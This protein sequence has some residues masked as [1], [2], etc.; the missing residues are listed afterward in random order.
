MATIFKTMCFRYCFLNNVLRGAKLMVGGCLRGLWQRE[1][2]M[3][4]WKREGV[5]GRRPS[6]GGVGTRRVQGVSH[7]IYFIKLENGWYGVKYHVNFV[8]LGLRSTYDP[9]CTRV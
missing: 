8:F 3:W 6:W 1:G 4:F 9:C 5:L 2:D 7:S